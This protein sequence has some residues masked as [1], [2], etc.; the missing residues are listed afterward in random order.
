MVEIDPFA[1]A[2]ICNWWTERFFSVSVAMSQGANSIMKSMR[3]NP[4]LA[5]MFKKQIELNIRASSVDA[6]GEDEVEAAE[7]GADD[8]H[9]EVATLRS[10]VAE[11]RKDREIFAEEKAEL[12][13]KHK[14]SIRRL[15]EQFDE[16][17][18]E[19]Q[20]SE[21]HALRSLSKSKRNPSR[22]SKN[23]HLKLQKS[24]RKMY[25]SKNELKV[26]S[27]RSNYWKKLHRFHSRI[28][29]LK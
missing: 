13:R 3:T 14:L 6:E 9:R 12:E 23:R 4:K 10:V 16:E 26:C 15:K 28:K 17:K 27:T 11:L 8:P 24:S 18:K 25:A 5:M 21:A 20:K 22:S 29:M 1:K 2:A 7:A 19:L